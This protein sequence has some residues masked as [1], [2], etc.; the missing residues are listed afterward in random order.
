[1]N[2]APKLRP[3]QEK[4][5]G[6]LEDAFT[7]APRVLMTL[8]TGAGKTV[9]FT[10]AIRRT[11]Q[12]GGTAMVVVHRRELLE[13]ASAALAKL[14]I[15]HSCFAPGYKINPDHQVVVASV[16]TLAARKSAPFAPTLL[17]LDEAHH[18]A[19][20]N[21]W[22]K[23][24][25]K[26]PD[27]KVLGATATACRLDGKGLAGS[28]CLLVNGP[29]TPSLIG[30]GFL[31][32]VR[33]F[34][35]RVSVTAEGVKTRRGDFDVAALVERFDSPDMA[36]AAVKHYRRIA[37]QA[38][39][40]VFCCTVAHAEHTASAFNAVGIPA[41][42]LHGGLSRNE[43]S[44]ILAAFESGCVRVLTSCDL[45][46]EGTDI[47][48]AQAAI[49]LRPTKSESLYLQQVG[50][51]LRAS[52]GKRYAVVID[53]AG[54]TERHGLPDDEREWSLAI[55]S[56]GPK[57]SASLRLQKCPECDAV[58][59]RTDRKCPNC[60]MEI[61]GWAKPA[62]PASSSNTAV[63]E[64]VAEEIG[65][66]E[67]TEHVQFTAAR[68]Y[69]L[70]T[71]SRSSFGLLYRMNPAAQCRKNLESDLANSMKITDSAYQ[72]L[73]LFMVRRNAVQIGPIV[74]FGIA[75]LEPDPR[76][77]RRLLR[78]E[79][80]YG[81]WFIQEREGYFELKRFL[82]SWRIYCGRNYRSEGNARKSSLEDHYCRKEAGQLWV[83]DLRFFNDGKLLTFWEL[84][85]LH[86]ALLKYFVDAFFLTVHLEEQQRSERAWRLA[87]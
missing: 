21:T 53:L 82:D 36:D 29:T 9:V 11:V 75:A 63:R 84:D 57:E 61:K 67:I 4:L 70:N 14:D 65:L 5:L 50:R 37:P 13:Q 86:Q 35:P 79:N 12:N 31:A 77:I 52:P 16:Q 80:I 20:H 68:E 28:F 44:E 17:V 54:N 27:A 47:P 19:G 25:Q 59:R 46:S 78:N 38:L 7:R 48:A 10:Q 51:V 2:A 83:D 58:F 56:S 76:E 33:V 71:T 81:E 32:P 45:I 49:L 39:A 73:R 18:A 85:L 60:G 42:C 87:A 41:A 69:R 26:W 66:V 1:M 24:I 40:M 22:T 23:L 62:R 74:P 3:Y 72:A 8:P 15:S 34:S 43:R 30:N 6:D 55:G 64:L